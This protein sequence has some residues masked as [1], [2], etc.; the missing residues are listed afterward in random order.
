MRNPPDASGGL[1]IHAPPTL[2][3]ALQGSVV[4]RVA[5]AHSKPQKCTIELTES[6]SIGNGSGH[7]IP[8]CCSELPQNNLPGRPGWL[9]TQGP[10]RSV[11]A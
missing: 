11:R 4:R 3:T 5:L 8:A 10:H 7:R 6:K 2:P 1:R 9:P